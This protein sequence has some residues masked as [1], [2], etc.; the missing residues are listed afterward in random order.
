[1]LPTASKIVLITAAECLFLFMNVQNLCSIVGNQV[2]LED[3]GC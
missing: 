1:M 3:Y 2:F